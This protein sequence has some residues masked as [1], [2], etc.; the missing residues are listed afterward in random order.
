MTRTGR[1]KNEPVNKPSTEAFDI[2]SFFF[3]IFIRIT[4]NHHVAIL[5][6]H[7]FDA[8]YRRRKNQITDVG[9][10]EPDR[11]KPPSF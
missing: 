7:I 2:K 6:R 4:Q 10:D 9:N 3:N 8:A 11:M 1:G 5:L